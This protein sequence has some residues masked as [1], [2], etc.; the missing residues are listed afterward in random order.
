MEA[1]SMRKVLNWLKNELVM[2]AACVMAII[3]AFF[4]PP[5][6]AYLEYIDEDVLLCLFCLMV[7]VAGFKKVKAFELAAEWVAQKSRHIRQLALGIILLT[8]V[9]AMFM[10]NDVALITLVPF[11]LIVLEKVNESRYAILIIVLQTIAA[12]IGSSLTP[13]GNPQ[14]LYLFSRYG[15][16]LSQ[17]L[18][19][20]TPIVALGGILLVLSTLLIEKKPLPA[21]EN[22]TSYAMDRKRFFVY[23]LLF[24]ISVLAVFKVIPYLWAGIIVTFFVLIMD[25]RLFGQVD[26]SL[27]VTFIGFFIFVGNIS[28]IE[29]VRDF[30]SQL[31]N[32]SEF[33]IS[34]LTSQIISNVP[35]A[36]LLSGFTDNYRELL[37]GVNVGGMGTL[38]ASLAS[39]I[40]Y[41]L[42]TKAHPKLSGRF[43]KVFTVFNVIFL[44]LLGAAALLLLNLLK[45]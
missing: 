1:A 43:F 44:I 19:L 6:R 32:R 10:T 30:L 17:F 42:Y 5:S 16:G 11:T 8:Y 4:V 12:N 15:L 31:L 35:A 40:S 18:L 29:Y 41:K 3:S 22:M 23:C 45:A 38:I 9:L 37:L 13:M 2:V 14:N 24:A 7:V 33:A 26:Y 25:R 39:V 34:V 20:M 21:M 28:K 36:V 27:L